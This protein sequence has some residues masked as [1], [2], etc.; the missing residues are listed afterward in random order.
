M[1]EESLNSKFS[2][3]NLFFF[4]I[5]FIWIFVN[6]LS[7]FW[8]I[9]QARNSSRDLAIA[10]ARSSFNKDLVY[11]R[12]AASHGGVYVPPT[13]K[14]PPN[15]YLAHL[16]DRDLTTTSGKNLTLIN[17]AYMSRQVLAMGKEQYGTQGHITSLNPIRPENKADEWET[18]CLKVFQSGTNE[19]FSIEEMN[20]KPYLRYMHPLLT[21]KPCLKCHARQGYKE[22]EIRGGISVSVPYDVFLKTFH[23]QKKYLI[24]WHLIIGIIGLFSVLLWRAKQFKYEQAIIEK[25]RIYRVVADNTYGWE[26]WLTPDN[27]FN[28]LSPSCEKISG[29]K[30]DD[31]ISN[32]NLMT[33]II[34]PD[35]KK[36]FNNHLCNIKDKQ[37]EEIE[38][39]IIHRDGHIVWLRHY[40][41]PIYD[42][43]NIFI[44][45]RGTNVDISDLKRNEEWMQ[46]RIRLRDDSL[47]YNIDDF[48]TKALDEAEK[49]T[50]S[51]IGFFHFLEPDQKTLSLQTW[52]T[53]TLKNMCKSTGK[54]SH[55]SVDLAGVWVDCIK[56][57]KAVIHNDYSGLSHK[58]GLPEGHAKIIR[59]L[60]VPIFH[61]NLIVAIIGVGNKTT[62]YD[63]KDVNNLTDF[64]NMVWDIVNYKKREE[65]KL[66]L[67]EQL[68]QFQKMETI[69][70]L[71]GGIAHDFNNIL[72]AILG[73]SELAYGKLSQADNSIKENIREVMKAGERAKG[74]I[75]QI[76][77]FSRKS[78]LEFMPVKLDIVVKEAVKLLRATIPVSIEIS[79]NI[80]TNTG[81]VLADQVQVH[82]IIMNIC[83]NA[84]QAMRPNKG[85]MGINLCNVEIGLEDT[86]TESFILT[87]GK[88]VK[89]QITDTGCG[90][91]KKTIERIFDPYFTTKPKGEGTGLGLS[92]VHGIVKSYGGHIS[93][94]SEPGKGSAFNIY[95]PLYLGHEKEQ[96]VAYDSKIEGGNERIL[97]LDDE[98]T[99][100][101]L[102]KTLLES[103]GYKV[104]DCTNVLEALKIFQENPENYDLIITDMTMPKMSG[105]EFARHL[106][107]IRQDIPIIICTGFSDQ[108]DEDKS[109]SLGI[110]AYL[111]KPVIRKD[112][113]DA[114]RKVLD[115]KKK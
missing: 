77:A 48:M 93:V 101:A 112:L 114:I 22:G 109:K 31:F 105:V 45:L 88:Y 35:D 113:S 65:E 74:L 44:G 80:D 36:I 53:N 69:G 82:Q 9:N 99:I 97:V 98:R 21:E 100:V 24:F 19:I 46:T 84:Y 58:K 81:T 51:T 87:P 59:E 27:K 8:N 25:E 104:T 38:F 91:D 14:T 28:Y 50:A 67:E 71:A 2:T 86:K 18:K 115:A 54:G 95:L 11:R 73:Y 108:L 75:Q 90:M 3:K 78:D 15:P 63:E 10:E 20:G 47:K 33:D 40:C 16:P 39:R 37:S 102:E 111:I 1:N 49:L 30:R 6:S 76:L 79:E 7:L 4:V 66:K 23:K 83:T 94:Y 52:S 5:I 72:S 43:K 41:L 62:D 60:V 42:E 85:R 103:L 68:R 17:P 55:Y 29:Y 110:N 26:Y 32:P 107:M 64:S 56:E 34:H 106:R 89:L 57:R 96:D 61:D 70:T 13:E 12:W 92:V